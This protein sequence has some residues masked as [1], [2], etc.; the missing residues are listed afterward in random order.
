MLSACDSFLPLW[1]YQVL[2]KNLL[3]QLV[4]RLTKGIV[5]TYQICNP[6]FKY[7]EALNPKRFL[8]NPSIG[9]LN[10]GYDNANSDLI[11]H[12]NLELVN[13]ERKRRFGSTISNN[14]LC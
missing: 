10:D 13:L 4:A 12:V 1:M 8:T 6:S 5:E 7:S 3:M 9:V 14:L 11:L 2:I